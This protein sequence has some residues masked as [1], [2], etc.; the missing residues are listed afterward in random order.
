[1]KQANCD[2]MLVKF[3]DRIHKINPFNQE[4][5]KPNVTFNRWLVPITEGANTENALLLLPALM[6]ISAYPE[7]YLCQI[8]SPNDKYKENQLEDYAKALYKS[9]R[10]SVGK[11]SICSKSITDAILDLA[12]QQ[13]SDVIL[14]GASHEGMLQKLIYGNIPEA[15]ARNSNRTIIIFRKAL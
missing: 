13:R 6:S 5:K 14:L 1:M 4:F 8:F 15:I 2:V 10:F 7:V 11:I 3:S 12:N 9:L